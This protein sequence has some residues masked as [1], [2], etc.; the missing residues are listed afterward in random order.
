MKRE[1]YCVAPAIIKSLGE[2]F[3]QLRGGR[4]S[5][6]TLAGTDGPKKSSLGI[7]ERAEIRVREPRII[8]CVDRLIIGD[9][10]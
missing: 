3:F 6:G 7:P 8:L 5:K 1:I 2:S 4:A 10:L 9:Q